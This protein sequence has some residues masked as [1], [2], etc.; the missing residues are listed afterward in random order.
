MATLL[1]TACSGH[2]YGQDEHRETIEAYG[3]NVRDMD[4]VTERFESACGTEDPQAWT[5]DYMNQGSD[6]GLLIVGV[7]QM[8][9]D[10][11]GE[12]EQALEKHG[13]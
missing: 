11:V 3:V 2:S 9:P 1:V 12:F 7:E 8:C 13:W 5:D 10:R 6:A 4:S